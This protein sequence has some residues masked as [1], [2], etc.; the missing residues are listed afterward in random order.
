M[1]KDISRDNLVRHDIHYEPNVYQANHENTQSTAHALPDHI[2]AVRDG[3]L[4]MDKI[5]PEDCA[6]TLRKE[7]AEH[8]SVNIGPNWCLHPQSSA[9]I[10]VKHHERVLQQSASHDNLRFCEKVVERVQEIL[11]DSEPEWSLFWRTEIFTLF[12]KE[13]REQP[14]FR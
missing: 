11:E 3:L 7:L 9:F 1:D 14:G 8:G 2:D 6:E 12:S 13:A 5:L 4:F 10:R